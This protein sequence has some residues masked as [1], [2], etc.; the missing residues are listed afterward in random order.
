MS[1]DVIRFKSTTAVKR[2]KRSVAKAVPRFAKKKAKK[3][4]K[5]QKGYK[6]GY[7]YKIQL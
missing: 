4:K 1:S 6:Q 2:W 3:I 5:G 7:R